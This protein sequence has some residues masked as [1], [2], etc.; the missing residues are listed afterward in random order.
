MNRVQ[1]LF[2]R[3]P[4]GLYRIGFGGLLGGRFLLLEHTGRKSGLQR[5]TVLEVLESGDDGP[6]IASGF[7]EG[8]QWCRNVMATPD[9]WITRGRTRTQAK[10]DRLGHDDA[11]EVFER[12][13]RDHARA[14]KVLGKRIGVSLVDDL[15]T[16]AERLPLFRLRPA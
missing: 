11:V 1:R 10:A 4:I 9:V 2:F 6:V 15:E 14:A 8:S 13:R 5:R 12:Y 7:G 16:A 3:A